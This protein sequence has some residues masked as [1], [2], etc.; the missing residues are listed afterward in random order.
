MPTAHR[1]RE[2]PNGEPQL[3]QIFS[4][5]ISGHSKKDHLLVSFGHRASVFGVLC[6]MMVVE[7]GAHYRSQPSAHHSS[8]QE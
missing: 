4:V 2:R 7:A 3:A 5:C 6:D 1:N 8:E